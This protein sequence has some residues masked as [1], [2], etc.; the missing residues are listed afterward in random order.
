MGNRPKILLTPKKTFDEAYH[1][2]THAMKATIYSTLGSNLRS[3]TFN[4]DMFLIIPLITDWHTITQRQDH[5][6][7]ENLIGENKK[8]H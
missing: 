2:A 3:L 7:N 6:I 4:R 8:H 5:L 1:N